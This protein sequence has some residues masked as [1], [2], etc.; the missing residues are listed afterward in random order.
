MEYFIENN[1]AI[2]KLGTRIDIHSVNE[3]LIILKKIIEQHQPIIIEA[4]EISSIDVAGFGRS[5]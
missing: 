2:L 1:K 3:L 4:Q 5:E